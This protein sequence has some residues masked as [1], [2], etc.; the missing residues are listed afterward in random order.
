MAILALISW[1]LFF[2]Q[3]K[4]DTSPLTPIPLPSLPATPTLFAEVVDCQYTIQE[5]DI[6][7]SIA[8]KFDTDLSHLFREDGLQD[9][10]D[11][12]STN[13][14]LI[15]NDISGE[16]CQTGDGKALPSSHIP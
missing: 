12:L 3:P 2:T 10:F 6:A 8:E 13:E 1:F 16:T 7:G 5:G 11:F 4:P 15:I 9:D 14:V